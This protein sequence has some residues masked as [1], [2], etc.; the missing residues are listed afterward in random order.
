[1]GYPVNNLELYYTSVEKDPK[2]SFNYE[3]K[4]LNLVLKEADEVVQKIMNKEFFESK[5]S[6]SCKHCSFIHYCNKQK[7]P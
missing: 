5:I 1:S 3:K 6:N 2:T 4:Q 7:K